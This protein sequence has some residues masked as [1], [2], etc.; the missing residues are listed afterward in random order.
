[1]KFKIVPVLV[2]CC[3]FS[4][5]S[6][7]VDSL[8]KILN[9]FSQANAL[10]SSR[11]SVLLIL[12]EYAPEGEWEG[13]NAELKKI[14]EANLKSKTLDRSK[15]R[16]FKSCLADAFN[17]EGFICQ[18]SKSN[19]F[20]ALENYRKSLTL[21]EEIGDTLGIAESY[22]N[23]GGVYENQGNITKSIEYYHKSL[24]LN[25]LLKNN[26]GIAIT[27]SNV[28]RIYSQ[29]KN[30]DKALEYFQSSLV[31]HRESKNEEGEAITYN[32]IAVVYYKMGDTLKALYSYEKSL[33][34]QD[35]LGNKPSKALLLNNIGLIFLNKGNFEKAIFNFNEGLEISEQSAYVKGIIFSLFNIG[36]FYT[37]KKNY[38]L[39][40]FYTK[41]SLK[42]AAESGSSEDIL[43]SSRA[44]KKLYQTVNNYLAAYEMSELSSKM[45]DSIQNEYAKKENIRRQFQY[46]FDEKERILG[47]E[48]E[49]EK[50][51]QKALFIQ[52][53]Q[54]TVIVFVL[55]VFV[56]FTTFSAIYFRTVIVKRKRELAYKLLV[57][58]SEIKALQAQMNPHF[59]FNSLNSGLELVRTS[60][61]E[62]ALSYLTKFSKLIRMILESS[63]KKM[64][65]LTE[66]IQILELYIELENM[67]FGDCFSYSLKVHKDLD[68]DNIEIPALITQPFIENAILHGLQNKRS[69]CS[70]E[71]KSYK[72][73]L[74]ITL[75]RMD[76]Y[77]KCVIEDN[78]IGRK[79]ANE[80]KS[81]KLFHHQSLGMEVTK[82]RL[83]L[84]DENKSSVNFFDL[85]DSNEESAGTR[86]ELNIPIN[87]M[88]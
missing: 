27:L 53:Q 47:Q 30:E 40:I 87:E 20:K 32:N 16:F 22:N 44:L 69:T 7:N 72:P 8:K 39:A 45:H 43:H 34:L 80:I 13:Y 25:N 67:R 74:D 33:V 28:G 55:I 15:I 68:A 61:K 23:I 21:R 78:G 73:Q 52:K 59:I 10:D 58:D 77:L 49:A 88:F 81:K 85:V 11:C 62:K 29:Q 48:Q 5:Y 84:V 26:Y 3:W 38:S 60:Q 17:G 66:E 35:R 63:N 24:R 14:S 54:Y 12:T 76:S 31:K 51:I 2:L 50:E 71:G 6:Q 65:S 42:L 70:E 9:Q 82:S 37:D 56:L 41:K 36:R 57:K 86:V 1:M 46:E 19:S 4:G 75:K 18:T 79:K 83:N 64:I